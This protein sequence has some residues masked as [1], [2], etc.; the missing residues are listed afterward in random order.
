MF[1]VP[2]RISFLTSA[3]SIISLTTRRAVS[4]RPTLS[5]ASPACVKS[6]V[7]APVKEPVVNLILS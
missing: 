5:A 2:V 3:F 4:K 6:P 1:G 7:L